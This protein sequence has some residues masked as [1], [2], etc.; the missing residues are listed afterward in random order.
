[1]DP[2][3]LG[4]LELAYLGD[5]VI[6]LMVRERLVSQS[7]AGVGKLNEL[8]RKYVKASNQSQAIQNILPLLSEKESD[9]YRRARNNSKISSPKSATTAEYRSATG[10]EALFA[11][12]YL[13][14]QTKRLN[15][16]FEIAYKDVLQNEKIQN[17]G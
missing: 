5:A 1:M 3:M 13:S 15:N 16:L 2:S 6:E 10:L 7:I 11:Y 9:V 4:S 12:L 17:Q 14:G 8:S